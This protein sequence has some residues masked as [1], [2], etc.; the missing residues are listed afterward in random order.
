MSERYNRERAEPRRVRGGGR[1]DRRERLRM[2]ERGERG[3]NE[4]RDSIA[5]GEAVSVATRECGATIRRCRAWR[6]ERANYARA[7]R[8]EERQ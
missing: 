4:V 3:A 6:T 7:E 1:R 8:S 5:N 2:N